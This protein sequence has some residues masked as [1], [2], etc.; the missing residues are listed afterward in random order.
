MD[1]SL[2]QEAHSRLPAWSE[3]FL[4]SGITNWLVN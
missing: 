1:G 3:S 4:Y 2:H